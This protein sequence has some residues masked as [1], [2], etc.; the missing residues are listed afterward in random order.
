[1]ARAP[2]TVDEVEGLDEE[3]L[4]HLGRGSDLL[5]KGQP[6]PAKA[7]LER[8]MELRPK[9]AKALGLL[10]QAYYKLGRYEDAAA[11][12]Q[13]LVDEN[14]IE[15]AARVNL[16]LANLKARRYEDAVKQLTIALDMNP[17]HRKAM[18]YLGLAL[19]ESGDPRR[20]REWFAR[21]GSEQMVARCDELLAARAA[22]DGPPP[23]HPGEQPEPIHTPVPG[24]LPPPSARDEIPGLAPFSAARLIPPSADPF[25]SDGRA[26]T[27]NV[28][29][30]VVA[31]LDGLFAARGALEMKPEVKRFRGRATDKPFGEGRRRMHRVAGEGALLYRAAGRRFTPLDLGAESGYFR[32]EVVFALEEPVVYENGRVPSRLSGDLNL[33]HLRGRGRFLLV[34]DG[35]PVSVEVTGE[36]PLRVPLDALVGWVGALT[37]RIVSWGDVVGGDDGRDGGALVELV[38][39]GRVLVD[40]AWDAGARGE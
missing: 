40:P 8:A 31:R 3:F 17:E 7:S 29:G 27:V 34:T 28:R 30:E 32:E 6:E 14:P 5:S 33:V 22:P 21:S 39:A 37:P 13:R 24:A 23:V 25:V 35:D 10:G 4:Y 36:A 20:A 15:A 38:G 18:G 12:Y 16:G 9:D 1:M 26:L 11:T 19:L 2:S